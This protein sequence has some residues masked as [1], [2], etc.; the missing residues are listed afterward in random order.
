MAVCRAGKRVYVHRVVKSIKRYH[1][2]VKHDYTTL[3][4]QHL[5]FCKKELITVIGAVV[6]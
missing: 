3:P 6:R 4:R 5:C 1:P 2:S